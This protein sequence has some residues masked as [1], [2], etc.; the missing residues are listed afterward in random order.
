MYAQGRGVAQ[1]PREAIRLY[2]QAVIQGSTLAQFHLAKL[3]AEGYTLTTPEERDKIPNQYRLPVSPDGSA[4]P[5]PEERAKAQYELAQLYLQGQ[6]VPADSLEATRWLIKAGEAGHLNSQCQLAKMYL[7]GRHTIQNYH[8]AIKWLTRAAEQN[9]GEAQFNLAKA[10]AEGLGVPSDLV[11]AYTWCNL[12][13]VTGKQDV[14]E[15]R[16]KLG[17]SMS[18]PQIREAQDQSAARLALGRHSQ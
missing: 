17:R 7:E 12:A 13:A 4:P 18:Q 1:N 8:E 2:Q 11:E 10:F 15:F 5:T 9:D 6:T 3:L 16:D 14:I